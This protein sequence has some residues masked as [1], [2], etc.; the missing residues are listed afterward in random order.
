MITTTTP[1]GVPP[2]PPP[3][4]DPDVV[5]EYRR[6]RAAAFKRLDELEGK[7][8]DDE[9]KWLMAFIGLPFGAWLVRSGRI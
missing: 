7:P 5:R 6:L 8:R 3:P 9:Y 1:P 2:A 4:L